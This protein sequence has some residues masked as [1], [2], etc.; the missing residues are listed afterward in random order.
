MN[1]FFY[2]CNYKDD[3]LA[4][5]IFPYMLSKLNPAITFKD[6]R[7]SYSQYKEGTAR[8]ALWKEAKIPNVFTL[9]ASF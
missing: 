1:A 8:V 6:C 5:R 9:E 2:G 7:F 3:P 4:T